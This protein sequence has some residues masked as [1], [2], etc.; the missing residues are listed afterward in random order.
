MTKNFKN[1]LV[2]KGY[3]QFTP[4]NQPSTVFDYLTGVKY[5]CQWENKTIEQLADSISEILPKY[6]NMGEH[7][8]RGRMKSRAVRCGLRQF[9]NFVME[10]RA[11]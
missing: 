2:N 9:N 6:C 7:F 10:S 5:V 4:N 3:A 11:A 8:I 1:W